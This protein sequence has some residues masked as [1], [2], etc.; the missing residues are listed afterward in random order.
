MRWLAAMCLRIW[1]S[2]SSQITLRTKLQIFNF[3]WLIAVD[4]AS[5]FLIAMLKTNATSFRRDGLGNDAS[6]YEYL[7]KM[8]KFWSSRI[9]YLLAR[10]T[11]SIEIEAFLQEHEVWWPNCSSSFLSSVHEHLR[12]LNFDLLPF[13][14]NPKR[15]FLR[16][17][18]TVRKLR[19]L[20]SSALVFRAQGG[21][22]A[23]SQGV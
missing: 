22:Q 5:T 1:R 17:P 18:E 9:M 8:G 14:V 20:S 15:Q 7:L 4:N 12:N 3:F 16:Y 10:H 21:A 23:L 13:E 2:S 11:S 19:F 6:F